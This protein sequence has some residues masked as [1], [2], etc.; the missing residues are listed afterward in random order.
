MVF[1]SG[2]SVPSLLLPILQQITSVLN[3][4][5]TSSQ[6]SSSPSDG[7]KETTSTVIVLIATS[8][9][10]W[11]LSLVLSISCALMALSLQRWARPPASPRHSLPEQARLRTLFAA[12]IE[13]LDLAFLIETLHCLIHIAFSVFIVGFILYLF[14]DIDSF[15]FFA[16]MAVGM[17]PI[18]MVYV[19]LTV[20]PIIRPGS[21]YS[22]P[23]S[24]IFAVAYA[25]CSYGTSLLLYWVKSLL[26]FS[27]AAQ[28]AVCRPKNGFRD[29]HLSSMK[30]K[31]AQELAPLLDGQVLKRTLDMLRSDDDLEQFF[32]AIPGFCASEIVDDPRRSLD[33]LG[34]QR[35][36]EALVEFWNRTLS[37]DRVSESV[38]GRRLVVCLRVIEA[39]DLSVVVP[40]ILYL[41]SA[42]L[43]G[44]SRSVEI[45]H[46]LEILRNGNV[47]SLARGIIASIISTNDEHDERWST[48]AM[49]E[50]GISKYVLWRYLE[51]G[52]S[53]LLANLIH[54]TRQFFHSLL[55]PNSDLARK[56]LSI[57]PSLSK[58]D[59][60]D[61]LPELQQDFCALWNEIVKQARRSGADNNPFID[62]LIEI[63]GLYVSLHGTNA[64]LTYFFAST[65]S[66]DDPLHQPDL[67]PLCT[68]PDHQCDLTTQIQEAGGSTTGG[69]SHSTTSTSPIPPSESSLGDVL[70]TGIVPTT[71]AIS[72]DSTTSQDSQ[73]VVRSP[74]GTGDPPRPDERIIVSSTASILLHQS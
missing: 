2:S 61:T 11:L 3:L 42:D 70:A 50:L 54:T 53:M 33:I 37:S 68:I 15:S 39:A 60:L 25:G 17:T 40:Q 49:D 12:G 71:A 4:L 47:A 34:Q 55:Q 65:A 56:S 22:T 64:A 62:I 36:S 67:Y 38:K 44:A 29:W 18:F 13:M 57:L 51:H 24:N 19:W 6:G 20:I 73:P 69:A 28:G 23:F 74:S 31:T 5:M 16:L 48:L 27:N 45:G 46:S 1:G 8:N 14:I 66:Y 72:L 32:E 30:F 43:R 63:R 52:D 59:V 21:P 10:F 26:R 58:F 35:L 41:F 7:Y 9:W